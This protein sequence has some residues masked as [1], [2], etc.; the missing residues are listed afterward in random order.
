MTRKDLEELGFNLEIIKKYIKSRK[1][2]ID[3]YEILSVLDKNDIDSLPDL[4]YQTLEQFLKEK[5]MALEEQINQD[6]ISK[7]NTITFYNQKI[8]RNL[9]ALGLIKAKTVASLAD[10]ISKA[11]PNQ[12]NNNKINFI[13]Q[14]L[15]IEMN[16]ENNRLLSQ[17]FD[18]LDEKNDQIYP[19]K[20]PASLKELFINGEELNIIFDKIE[21]IKSFNKKYK[22]VLKKFNKEKYNYFNEFNRDK[23]NLYLFSTEVSLLEIEECIK[24]HEDKINYST[25]NIIQD[26]IDQ[27]KEIIDSNKL[28]LSRKKKD[29][30]RTL[31]FELINPMKEVQKDIQKWYLENLNNPLLGINQ[32]LVKELKLESVI[33]N[34]SKVAVLHTLCD[35]REKELHNFGYE[36][37]IVLRRMELKNEKYK[38]EQENIINQ[39]VL[40]NPNLD[41]ENISEA[42]ELNYEL[43]RYEDDGNYLVSYRNPRIDLFLNTIAKNKK[44][45]K[46]KEVK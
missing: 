23:M 40:L 26:K 19:L 12:L 11:M 44:M 36:I 3:N 6:K 39:L 21:D 43:S 42:L 35:K 18:I 4:D 24:Y 46:K 9:V 1:N 32:D 10:D 8:A 31:L 34:P 45:V 29:K 20:V 38:L 7:E 14:T 41:K 28:Y 15:N 5:T 22:E 25:L 2:G 17:Y 27:I 37:E 16:D 30:I 13:T 33:N